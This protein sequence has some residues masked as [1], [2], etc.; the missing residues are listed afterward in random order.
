[1]T[2]EL[3]RPLSAAVQHPGTGIKCWLWCLTGDEIISSLESAV[4]AHPC[5]VPLPS[6]SL[7][8]RRQAI[9]PKVSASGKPSYPP[10]H[11]LIR[12]GTQ[13]A[14]GHS[15]F[16]SIINSAKCSL[17]SVTHNPTPSPLLLP[18]VEG[19]WETDF[20]RREC[21]KQKLPSSLPPRLSSTGRGGK[22]HCSYLRNLPSKVSYPWPPCFI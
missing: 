17:R 2:S 4:R 5:T 16:S 10:W 14:Q 18:G 22:R 3:A 8:W 13:A 1:M 11:A 6:S 20:N 9:H 12:V 21:N 7:L 19:V 15:L